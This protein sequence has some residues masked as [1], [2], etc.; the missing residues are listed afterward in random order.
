MAEYT[1][2]YKYKQRA[3]MPFWYD[4]NPALYNDVLDENSFMSIDDNYDP[5]G[6]IKVEFF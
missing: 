4:K 5:E 2:P 1:I 3:E 6:H